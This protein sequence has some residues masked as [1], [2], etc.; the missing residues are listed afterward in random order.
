MKTKSSKDPLVS[1]VLPSYNGEKYI[2]EA[3]D[4]ILSQSFR[5]IELI[6]VDD[7][8]SDNTLEIMR[9]YS[10]LDD[11]VSVIHNDHN[12]KLPAALNIGIA[13][14]RGRFISWTSDDNFFDSIA[15]ENMTTV[16]LSE[17]DST[18]MVTCK[19]RI[20]NTNDRGEVISE[21]ISKDFN[22]EDIYSHNTVGACF[23]YRATVIGEIGEYD[24]NLFCAEDYDYWLR[25][26]SGA[27]KIKYLN[28]VL[29][30]YRQHPKNLTATRKKEIFIQTYKV[31]ERYSDRWLALYKNMPERLTSLFYMSSMSKSDKTNNIRSII[32]NYLP[33]LKNELFDFE[34]TNNYIIWGC[35]EIGKKTARILMNRV[36]CFVDKDSK[37]VGNTIDGIVVKGTE[38]IDRNDKI[39][40]IVAVN[41]DSM[42]S[43]INELNEMGKKNFYTIWGLMDMKHEK[44]PSFW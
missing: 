10:E 13:T 14:A 16:L 25:I 44:Y 22:E 4:S 37:K 33:V 21:A 42:Y 19:Y 31:L 5:D 38:Y 17:P 24:T 32:K 1:V 12:C 15:L 26:F 43:V 7:C 30:T 20:W 3:I 36:C 35:G 11:R 29:Y 28:K 23:L 8:S 9:R 27:G 18:A 41:T 6:L 40:V 34:K 2:Q 39:P